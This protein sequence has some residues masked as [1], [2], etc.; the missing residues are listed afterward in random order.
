MSTE[1]YNPKSLLDAVRYFS[2]PDVCHEYMIRVRWANERPSCPKCGSVKIGEIKSRRMFQCKNAECRKQFSTKVGTIFEDS[3]LGLDKWFVAVWAIANA[4][5]GISSCELARALEV[6]Q[7]T[8]WHMLHRVRL[9]MKTKSF[10]KIIGEVESDETAVGGKAKNMHL[11]KRKEKIKGTGFSGKAVV[12]GMLERGG[13]VRCAVVPNYRINTLQ[14]RV[15]EN[16]EPGASLYTD[17]LPSYNGLAGEYLHEIVDH[18]K[19]YVRGRV[20]TNG[21]ENF[22]SLLKRSIQGTYVAVDPAHLDRYLDEQAFRFNKRKGNDA[23]RFLE[24][25][26]SVAGKRLTYAELTGK[27]G[28]VS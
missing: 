3:P 1:S 20:H 6:T 13:E 15:R 14:K 10:R 22:W 26:L 19:E 11:S 5:N 23:T 27:D 4:K 7:K 8:A 2:D 17:K 21:L 16:V 12:H 28:A 9:A 24:A 18:A 25:M